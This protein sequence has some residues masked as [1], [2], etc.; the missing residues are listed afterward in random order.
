[1][2][3]SRQCASN[4]TGTVIL[5]W[6]SASQRAV[7]IRLCSSSRKGPLKLGWKFMVLATLACGEIP[8]KH[9]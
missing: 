3:V 5:D 1:M 7:C 2:A 4:R 9:V 8:H 6:C